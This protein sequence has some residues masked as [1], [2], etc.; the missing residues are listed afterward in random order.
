[1]SLMVQKLVLGDEDVLRAEL[2]R[3]YSLPSA[4]LT[5]GDVEEELAPIKLLVV[6]VEWTG[7]C[8]Y[9]VHQIYLLFF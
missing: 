7:E 8:R 2:T 1:M 4:V 6:L 9:F 3:V 5:P